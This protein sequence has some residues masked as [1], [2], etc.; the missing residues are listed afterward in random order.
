M[1]R[2]RGERASL[3]L[4]RGGRP[5]DGDADREPRVRRR[6]DAGGPGVG[7][8]GGGARGH[9]RLLHAALN[10]PHRV[11]EARRETGHGSGGSGGEGGGEAERGEIVC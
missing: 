9:R 6:P 1:R 11:G 8:G 4:Q 3:Q 10:E 7:G 5:G 2:H